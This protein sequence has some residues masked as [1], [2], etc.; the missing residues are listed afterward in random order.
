MEKYRIMVIV[1]IFIAFDVVSGLLKAF[2]E[3]SINSTKMREGLL[4]KLAEIIA[5]L[6]GMASN[7]VLPMLGIDIGV[8]FAILIGTYTVVMEL[9]S[10]IENIG[11]I[12]EPLGKILGKAFEKLK[13][14]EE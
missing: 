11:A 1:L 5:V 12:N 14:P 8:D 9:C 6:L 7:V 3:K 13:Q 10:V 2:K 4:S